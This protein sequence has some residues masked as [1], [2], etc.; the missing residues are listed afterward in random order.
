MGSWQRDTFACNGIYSDHFRFFHFIA[1]FGEF[2]QPVTATSSAM[3]FEIDALSCFTRFLAYHSLAHTDTLFDSNWHEY[4]WD[5]RT[6][7]M[8]DEIP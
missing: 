7:I 3:A 5:D 4:V 8:N 1:T 2:C 6:E